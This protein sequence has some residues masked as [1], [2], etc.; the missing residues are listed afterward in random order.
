MEVAL[1]SLAI[2]FA[3]IVGMFIGAA[4]QRRRGQQDQDRLREQVGSLTHE[5]S[6][7]VSRDLARESREDLHRQNAQDHELREKAIAEM[8]KP[9]QLRLDK[10]Q[11]TNQE[12]HRQVSQEYGKLFQQLGDLQKQTTELGRHSH[13]L[14]VALKGSSQAR[15]SFGEIALK[16]IVKMAGMTEYCDFVEQQT[17]QD[18]Q[19][20]D[21]IVRLPEGDTIPVDAKASMAA[22]LEAIEAD[23]PAVR[24]ECQRRH[25]RDMRARV[26]ELHRKRYDEASGGR[27]DFTVMFVPGEPILSAAY[28]ADPTLQADAMEKRVLIATPVTL[29][30]LLRTT[31]T[32]WSLAT[33]AEHAKEVWEV[34]LEFHKRVTSFADH[35]EKIGKGLTGALK[36]YNSAVGSYEKKVLPQGR[37]VEELEGPTRGNKELADLARIEQLP[38]EVKS[39]PATR[40]ADDTGEA[41]SA[42]TSSTSAD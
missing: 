18:G 3:L 42:D 15:G 39:A 13:A 27:V 4:Q 5:I 34:A 19:R 24:A 23:D 32:M 25:A 36:S 16:N 40:A 30:A 28:E 9:F 17:G 6:A 12:M 7:K 1:I 14:G 8:L 31:G 26:T 10:L 38:R 21:M 29:M 37:R 41:A 11:S 2:V 22:Y 35:L 20:P 33:K